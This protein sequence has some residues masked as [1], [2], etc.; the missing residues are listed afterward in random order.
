[1]SHVS[2]ENKSFL[3][4]VVQNRSVLLISRAKL[5]QR[6][7][8]I[9]NLPCDIEIATQTNTAKT[10]RTSRHVPIIFVCCL[11]TVNTVLKYILLNI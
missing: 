4:P 9:Y 5:E 10:A 2:L 3:Q 11:S 7:L 1:M 8:K 6:Y